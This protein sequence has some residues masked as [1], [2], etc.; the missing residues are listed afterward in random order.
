MEGL[1]VKDESLWPYGNQRMLKARKMSGRKRPL[2]WYWW[3]AQVQHVDQHECDNSGGSQCGLP[4]AVHHHPKVTCTTIVKYSTWSHIFFFTSLIFLSLARQWESNHQSIPGYGGECLETD[5]LSH[6][7]S[8]I[9]FINSSQ[10]CGWGL[11]NSQHHK[12]NFPLSQYWIFWNIR[13][14]L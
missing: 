12:S 3:V 13:T 6:T 7:T 8:F 11:P 1:G 2:L 9:D 10:P 4:C 14:H 5:S